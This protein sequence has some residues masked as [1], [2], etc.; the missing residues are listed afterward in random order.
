MDPLP[1]PWSPT[2]LV[3]FYALSGPLRPSPCIRLDLVLALPVSL[4][5]CAL[6]AGE[7]AVAASILSRGRGPSKNFKYL[8]AVPATGKMSSNPPDRRS[9]L[10]LFV[11]TADICG[12]SEVLCVQGAEGGAGRCRVVSF[13]I[14]L[15]VSSR[16]PNHTEN[17]DF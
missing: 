7:A 9:S 1:Y 5:G 16:F 2:R 6:D 4:S 17:A 10:A 8:C 3:G 11:A 14:W 15:L 12:P 13:Q